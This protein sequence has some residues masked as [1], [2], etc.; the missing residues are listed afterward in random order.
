[1][2]TETKSWLASKTVWFN[3]ITAALGAIGE[4]SQVFPVSKHPLLYTNVV[5]VGN[6]ILRLLTYKP[7]SLPNSDN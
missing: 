5:A 2:A 4:L 6:I 7:I 1:M 3:I